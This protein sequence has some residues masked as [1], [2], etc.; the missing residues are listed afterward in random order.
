MQQKGSMIMREKKRE[1][2]VQSFSLFSC[3]T[4]N[5]NEFYTNMLHEF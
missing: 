5:E 4:S 1:S 3:R 2:I